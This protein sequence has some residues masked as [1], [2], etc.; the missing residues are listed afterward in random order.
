MLFDTQC[1]LWLQDE[2]VERFSVPTLRTVSDP[3]TA[4]FLS[5]AS[6][7]EI[8]IKYGLGKLLLPRPPDQYVPV[9]LR[10]SVTQ[11]LAIDLHHVCAG[12]SLPLHHRDPFDRLL[13]A[14]A[15]VEGLTLLS[16]D[17][18]FAEYGIDLLPV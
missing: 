14:Q 1:W 7:W 12:A 15:R 5:L 6:I 18:R 17:R 16:S 2:R 8:S 13:I 4:R 9:R 10:T 11:P 3:N